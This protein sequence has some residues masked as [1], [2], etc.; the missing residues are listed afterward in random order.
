MN[1]NIDKRAESRDIG[2][3]AV[4]GHSGTQVL[5]LADVLV[6]LEGFKSLSWVATGLVQ[7][8]EDVVDGLQAEVCFHEVFRLDFRD[9]F[10]VADEVFHLH[11]QRLGHL[12][13]DV[14][15]FRVDGALVKWIF[16]VMDAQ[17]AR[18]LLEGLVAEARYFL[19]LFAVLETAFF[20]A[21]LDD[22]G[23]QT[24]ADAAD[25]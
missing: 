1:A 8:G 7:F 9:E 14:V 25:V 20:L 24:W 11:V 18:A 19:E 17:K 13:N 6:E 16:T 15:T 5:D 4:Q 21:V 3:D 12:F 23:G 22:V 2:H 10:L